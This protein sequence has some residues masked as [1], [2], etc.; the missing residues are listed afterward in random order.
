M[1]E[2]RPAHLVISNMLGFRAVLAGGQFK[3]FTDP[4]EAERWLLETREAGGAP[5]A[6]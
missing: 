2:S 6:G 3:V 5:D 4:A 1:V